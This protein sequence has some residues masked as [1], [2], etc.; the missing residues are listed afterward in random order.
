MTAADLALG[1]QLE[2]LL[3][4]RMGLHLRHGGRR[5][6][7]E[8]CTGRQRCLRLSTVATS[9]ARGVGPGQTTPQASATCAARALR[10]R[11]AGSSAHWSTR[12]AG[13]S[14][15]LPAPPGRLLVAA[16]QLGPHARVSPC[17]HAQSPPGRARARRDDSSRQ[18]PRTALASD[19]IASLAFTR[20]Q[21]AHAAPPDGL[22]RGP[23]PRALAGK[24]AR[25][26]RARALRGDAGALRGRARQDRRRL[27]VGPRA[28]RGGGLLPAHALGARASGRCIAARRGWRPTTRI[29]PPAARSPRAVRARRQR[30][31][32]HDPAD[33]DVQSLLPDARR[34][35]V[36]GEREGQAD[37]GSQGTRAT[38]ATSRT[39]RGEAGA[40]Q[41]QI[42][43]LKGLM[44]GLVALASLA[45]LLALALS[46]SRRARRRPGGARGLPGRRLVR[47]DHERAHAHE[48]R[49]VRRQPRDR[50]RVRDQS[51]PRP[52]ATSG[53]SSRCCSTSPSRAAC[54]QIQPPEPR[55]A[56]QFAFFVAFGS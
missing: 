46:A 40:R 5:R 23:R 36:P 27:L 7:A 15:L 43:Y 49:Q 30:P 22:L 13:G 10:R 56:A 48:R 34:H 54:A 19:L 52:P 20:S 35:G 14:H 25:R 12:Q 28:C 47:G 24:H 38:W 8:A 42:V 4:A 16:S 1:G 55:G 3:G 33:R 21:L 39:T 2:A 45:P 37:A 9:R 6:I 18:P 41:A 44:R 26:R 29:S 17:R 53:R 11:T 50:A 32:R 31:V 51:R